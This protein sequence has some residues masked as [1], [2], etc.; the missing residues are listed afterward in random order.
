MPLTEA[1]EAA[2]QKSRR[3]GS[4]YGARH[5]AGDQSHAGKYG[6]ILLYTSCC[7]CFLMLSVKTRR[8]R[9][10]VPHRVVL[11]ISERSDCGTSAAALAYVLS[12][13]VRFCLFV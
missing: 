10:Q 4:R 11:S 1:G 7:C 12:L 6:E 5:P 2:I 13:C 8:A 9:P 3:D